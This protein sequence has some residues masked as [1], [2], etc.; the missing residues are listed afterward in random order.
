[1]RRRLWL[2]IA[3]GGCVGFIPGAPGTYA[4]ALTAIAF[5]G[6]YRLEFRIV[7]ELHVSVLCLI[8]AVGTLAA[9][10][11][12]RIYGREDP[13]V[14]V[15]DEVAG[16]LTAFLFLPVTVSHIVLGF[17]LFRI[18]D[19]WKPFPIRRLESL[20]NGVGIMA[21]DLLAGT[22]ANLTLQLLVLAAAS[23]GS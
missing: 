4:S 23:A 8:A 11:A 20:Q 5:Y 18:F 13:P 6:I 17:A 22:Y 16:Q 14:V 2:F 10:Q 9:A 1:M 12:S 15:V 19:I 3:S 7:P 21:D